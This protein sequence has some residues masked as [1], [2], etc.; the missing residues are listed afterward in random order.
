MELFAPLFRPKEFFENMGIRVWEKGY[1][2]TGVVD[3]IHASYSGAGL[4][5]FDGC[6]YGEE[7]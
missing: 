7:R 3:P 5:G 2:H 1:G 6:R 4:L